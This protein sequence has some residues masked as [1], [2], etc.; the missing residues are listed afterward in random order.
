MLIA[1]LVLVAI[2]VAA[3]VGGF[4][5]VWRYG[6]PQPTN[7]LDI[8]DEAAAAVTSA[9]VASRERV[10]LASL[11]VWDQLLTV[12]LASAWALN[13][14]D[15]TVEQQLRDDVRRQGGCRNLRHGLVRIVAALVRV[16][17]EQESDVPAE[18]IAAG[19]AAQRF[20][21]GCLVRRHLRRQRSAD[22]AWG[23]LVQNAKCKK[24]RLLT[25][26]GYR[27][28]DPTLLACTPP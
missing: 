13:L 4:W 1:V 18:D 19:I 10:Q 28:S 2:A 5:L 11:A 3:G 12:S 25:E 23:I 15:P 7:D 9:Y 26:T 16:A 14:R 8:F 27:L 22:P 20:R 21:T 6:R 17:L 24:A